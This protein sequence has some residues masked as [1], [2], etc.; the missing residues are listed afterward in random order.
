[1]ET[2]KII[3]LEQSNTGAIHLLKEGMFYRAYNRSAMR[4]CMLQPFKVNAKYIKKVKQVIYYCGF[5][6]SSLEKIKGKAIENVYSI[7]EIADKQLVISGLTDDMDYEIWKAKYKPVEK[8]N[9]IAAEQKVSYNTTTPMQAETILKKISEF[10]LE[11]STPMQTML[12]VQE[13]KQMVNNYG[14]SV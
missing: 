9:I 3:E 1:M 8:N 14:A 13:L 2:K 7:D 5:P 11:N 6:V 4:L 12:F 10:P